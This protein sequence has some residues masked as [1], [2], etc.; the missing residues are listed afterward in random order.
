MINRSAAALLGGATRY[1]LI[2]Q[3]AAQQVIDQCRVRIDVHDFN[4]VSYLA[5]ACHAAIFSRLHDRLPKLRLR[6]APLL[7]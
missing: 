7:D 6:L 2:L 3:D 5:V 4:L 1:M